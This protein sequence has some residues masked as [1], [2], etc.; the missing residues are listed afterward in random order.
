MKTIGLLGGM[1]WESTIP[2]Y[3]QINEQ[4]KQQLG[5]LHSARLVLY[6]VDFQ[7]IEQLQRS[8][9]W[10]QAGAVLAEAAQALQ[11]AGADFIVLCTN[12]MHKVA[13][14]IEAAVAIP[15][16]HIADPTAQAISDAGLK[17]VGL[18]GTRFTMEQSFYRERLEQQGLK[19]LVPEEADR[20]LVH[21]VI[22]QELCL[23]K[24]LAESRLQYQ[25]VMQQLVVQGAEAIIL[26]CTEIGLLLGPA[27]AAVPLFDTTALHARASVAK[28]LA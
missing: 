3:R 19:V 27:D 20:E 18:L 7:Q 26:G 6:S 14:A 1:S 12:T 17:T 23:G 28:A 16:L 15:L 4:V 5:G 10:A 25:Q 11:A 9:D 13:A 24:V 22:Y 8:G 21:Q 2:Y